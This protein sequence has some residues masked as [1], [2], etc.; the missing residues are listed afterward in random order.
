V[1]TRG[2]SSDG[3]AADDDGDGQP[4]PPQPLLGQRKKATQQLNGLQDIMDQLQLYQQQQQQ[5]D[6]T[7]TTKATKA[8]GLKV[9]NGYAQAS[10]KTLY[11][12]HPILQNHETQLK[13]LL[14]LGIQRDT[15]VTYPIPTGRCVTQVYASAVPVAYG[16]APTPAW[17]P[18][19]CIVLQAAYEGTLLE[20]V[21][22]HL[23]HYLDR[24]VP[25]E[26]NH[27]EI[28]NTA[29]SSSAALPL[30]ASSQPPPPPTKV[31]LT[32]VGGG[33]FGNELEWILQAMRQ[34]HLAVVPFSN[35]VALDIQVVHFG[36][37]P[38]EAQ[39]LVHWTQTTTSSSLS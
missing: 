30:I 21:R 33:V 39:D 5:Q 9:V 15:E 27:P 37:I 7:T 6:A 10:T 2:S 1:N 8:H 29:S 24:N 35:V 25:Q 36:N 12:L 20:A 13:G 11:Q 23:G 17:Q 22:Q 19:A 38:P 34:A 3:D 31:F 28:H 26:P 16:N 14:R 32:L 4:Q 18:L